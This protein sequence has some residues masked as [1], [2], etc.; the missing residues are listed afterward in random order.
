MILGIDVGYSMTKVYSKKGTDIFMSTVEDGINDVNKKAVK[1]EFEGREYTIGE[2][3]G[4]FSVDLNKINDKTFRFCLFTAIARA[5]KNDTVA[6][7]Q[8]VTGLPVEY[9]KTQKQQLI[10]SLEGLKVTLVLNDEPKKFTI[11]RCLVFPQ[12]AGLF[13]LNPNKFIG[14]NIVVDIGGLTVDVSYF[15]E[16]TLSKSGTYELGM[17]KLYDK[18]I[19]AVKSEYQVSYDTLQAEKIITGKQ[20]IKDGSIIDVTDL[21]NRVLRTHAETITMNIKNGFKEYDTSKRTFIGGG[22]YILKDFLPG[23][24]DKDDIYTNAKAFYL[25]GVDKFES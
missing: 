22:S 2:K 6:E 1:I 4:N 20:I 15:D 13:I 17:L 24:I 5:M 14:D 7:I 19:Q 18:I 3:T 21:V 23:I 12:S 10:N 8:L 25:V 11:T 9:Y 16:M